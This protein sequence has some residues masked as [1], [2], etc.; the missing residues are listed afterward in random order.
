MPDVLDDTYSELLMRWN[1]LLYRIQLRSP[2]CEYGCRGS[3]VID[4]M[5][6]VVRISIG[7]KFPKHGLTHPH[8]DRYREYTFRMSMGSTCRRHVARSKKEPL[9]QFALE[10]T[11]NIQ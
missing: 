2:A 6:L 11:N 5:P 10:H 1:L 3:P 9:I 8:I 7:V 4:H